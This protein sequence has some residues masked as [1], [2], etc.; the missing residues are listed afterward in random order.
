MERRGWPRSRRSDA[1]S[2]GPRRVPDVETPVSATQLFQQEVIRTWA[3][4]ATVLEAIW[5]VE[6][7]DT[8]GEG[9]TGRARRPGGYQVVAAGECW[10]PVRR[11]GL[12][13]RRWLLLCWAWRG[14]AGFG[15]TRDRLCRT[16]CS[17]LPLLAG[18]RGG[19]GTQLP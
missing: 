19:G 7:P 9:L 11:P 6:E 4:E 5:R 10:V 17:A 1:N 15:G 3:P 16:L 12:A 14:L 8:H 2:A 13:Q 18:S